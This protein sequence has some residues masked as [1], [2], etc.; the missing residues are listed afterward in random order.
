M[1]KSDQR[2]FKQED[3][4]DVSVEQKE[5]RCDGRVGLG[6]VP[7]VHLRGKG[8]DPRAD[9]LVIDPNLIFSLSS[10]APSP[11][12]RPTPL[13]SST[14]LLKNT[15]HQ[16]PLKMPDIPAP[17]TPRV[18]PGAPPPAPLSKS[19]KKKRKGGAKTKEESEAGSHVAAETTAAT[20][21]E[22]KAAVENDVKE[23]LVAPQLAVQ[24][25]E[26]DA[27]TP[28]GDHR[29]TPIVDMLNKRLK[30]NSKKIVSGG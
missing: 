4:L 8:P 11:L 18:V 20:P 28:V 19:Q 24:P 25:S 15:Q 1:P 2:T 23:E 16:S 17:S 7:C 9:S 22:E 21:I 27:V 6:D 13:A 30:A 5:N 10:L 12:L 14:S 29:A 3:F 26:G